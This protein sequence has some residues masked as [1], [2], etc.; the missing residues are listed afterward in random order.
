VPGLWGYCPRLRLLTVMSITGKKGSLTYPRAVHLLGY[1]SSG[2][3]TQGQDPCGH[4]ELQEGVVISA[5]DGQPDPLVA[6]DRDRSSFLFWRS[7]P[8]RLLGDDIKMR[9]FLIGIR[10][11]VRPLT[12][13]W[14][15]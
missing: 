12:A 1:T 9:L 10:D 5:L 6:I 3:L 15:W 4:H 11:P 2:R 14:S 13:L 8:A 7:F